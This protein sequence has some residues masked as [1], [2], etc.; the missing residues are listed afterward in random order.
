MNNNACKDKD[1]LYDLWYHKD[2]GYKFCQGYMTFELFNNRNRC[3][4]RLEKIERYTDISNFLEE[5]MHLVKT[6]IKRYYELQNLVYTLKKPDKYKKEKHYYKETIIYYDKGYP[7]VKL[8]EEKMSDS[9]FKFYL[10][11]ENKLVMVSVPINIGD[12]YQFIKQLSLSVDELLEAFNDI[13][14]E[15]CKIKNVKEQI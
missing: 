10:Y 8:K 11:N 6:L 15:Y 13:Y 3:I 4:K 9:S 2:I 14:D 5:S 7:Y 1:L 12:E